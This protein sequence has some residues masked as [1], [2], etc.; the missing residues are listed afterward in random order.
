LSFFRS[1][2]GGGKQNRDHISAY[3]TLMRM[4]SA[5]TPGEKLKARP[6]FNPRSP[7][8]K[9]F[10]W[11]FRINSRTNMTDGLSMLP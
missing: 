7:L 2:G 5:P 11:S 3:M 6:C 9:A 10:L 8:A 1:T 4:P